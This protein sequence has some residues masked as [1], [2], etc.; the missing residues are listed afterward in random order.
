MGWKRRDWFMAVDPD[1][2]FDRAGNIGPTLWWDGEVIGSWAITADASVR[3]A[4]LADRGSDARRAVDRAALQL[5]TRLDGAVVTPA[6]RTPL[7][8]ALAESATT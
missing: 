3:T 7:E 6:V 8:R 2:V 5:Q 4:I 1:Q